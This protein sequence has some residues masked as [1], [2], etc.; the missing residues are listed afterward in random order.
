MPGARRLISPFFYFFGAFDDLFFYQFHD[1]NYGVTMTQVLRYINEIEKKKWSA[2]TYATV[3]GWFG[4]QP[5]EFDL[6]INY[7][8]KYVTPSYKRAR[9]EA[10]ES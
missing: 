9:Q 5:S 7:Q 1:R 10:P 6:F 3:L 2:V 4:F 8:E